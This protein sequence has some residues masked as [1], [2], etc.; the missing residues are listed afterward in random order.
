MSTQP[1]DAAQLQ[2]ELHEVAGRLRQS[3][4]LTPAQQE[5]LADLLDELSGALRATQPLSPEMLHVAQTAAHL[6]QHLHN[7]D[8]GLLSSLRE[9]LEQTALQVE[10]QAPLLVGITRRLIDA[11]ANIGI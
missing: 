3:Q 10:T 7:Q 4:H 5:E 2:T 6:A 8:G 9:R 11:L 1:P